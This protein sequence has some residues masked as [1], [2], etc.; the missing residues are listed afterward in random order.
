MLRRARGRAAGNGDWITIA[1]Q[2]DCRAIDDVGDVEGR[3]GVVG[4]AVTQ[5]SRVAR[6]VKH[7]RIRND[8]YQN[9]Q[10]CG[11]Q[12]GVRAE[13]LLRSVRIGRAAGSEGQRSRIRQ[14]NA[15]AGGHA[16]G[17][18]SDTAEQLHRRS[19]NNRSDRKRQV[20]GLVCLVVVVVTARVARRVEVR[21]AGR[22]RCYLYLKRAD[23]GVI[24]R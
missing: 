13:C 7:R 19:G 5:R 24:K 21:R 14:L 23:V 9:R 18:W 11:R 20:G 15:R 2:V 12:A 16:T 6:W 1:Q 3:A 8:R 10:S 17:D 22:A 4:D